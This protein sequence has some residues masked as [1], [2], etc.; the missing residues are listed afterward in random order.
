VDDV[1]YFGPASRLIGLDLKAHLGQTLQTLTY[2][3]RQSSSEGTISAQFF[4]DGNT[5]SVLVTTAKAPKRYSGESLW[6]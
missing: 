6:H 4:V 3:L 1:S 2:A 5:W